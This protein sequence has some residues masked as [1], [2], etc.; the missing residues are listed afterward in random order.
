RPNN[1]DEYKILLI[2][3]N[4]HQ[5]Y[6]LNNNNDFK[7]IIKSI[8]KGYYEIHNEN[9]CKD[10]GSTSYKFNDTKETRDANFMIEDADNTMIIINEMMSVCSLKEKDDRRKED[11]KIVID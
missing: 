11:I 1:F 8:A 2:G 7:M 5:S 3:E 10:E 6:S 9:N 4:F